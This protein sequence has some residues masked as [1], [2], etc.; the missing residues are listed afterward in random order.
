MSA[1]KTFKGPRRRLVAGKTEESK[2]LPSDGSTELAD[3]PDATNLTSENFLIP[4][5][6]SSLPIDSGVD[7]PCEDFTLGHF[8]F[9]MFRLSI[10]STLIEDF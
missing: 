9:A 4:I 7:F 8:G 2:I 5:G 10:K 3:R 1:Q 6:S